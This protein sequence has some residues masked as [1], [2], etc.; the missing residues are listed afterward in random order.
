M[1]R[2]LVVDDSQNARDIAGQCL[3]DHGMKPVFATNGREAVAV[4][5]KNPPDAV[6]TDLHMPKMDGLELVKYVRNRHSGLPVPR[7][8]SSF[9]S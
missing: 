2:I 9:P 8:S 6:L 5:E 3:R 4:L 7:R 1:E